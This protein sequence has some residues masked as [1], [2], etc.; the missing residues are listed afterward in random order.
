MLTASVRLLRHYGNWWL[1]SED[2]VE[3][4]DESFAL[5]PDGDDTSNV[6]DPQTSPALDAGV[7]GWPAK[8]EEVFK[9]LSRSLVFA[10]HMVGRYRAGFPLLREICLRVPRQSPDFIADDLWL[11]RL[12]ARAL[13][14]LKETAGFRNC[15]AGCRATL[16]YDIDLATGLSEEDKETLLQM[17]QE[18][19][20]Q[21]DDGYINIPEW[22]AGTQ[23]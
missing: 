3:A 7:Q 20:R 12:A 18:N 17:V 10:I 1:V 19:P 22:L 23:G 13:Y 21:R 5:W 11:Q 9:V 2:A 15:F 8:D 6:E 14:G 4:E 16:L